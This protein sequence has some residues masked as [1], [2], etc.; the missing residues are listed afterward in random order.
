[1]SPKYNSMAMCRE[2]SCRA[3][4]HT[5]ESK[6]VKSSNEHTHEPISKIFHC[7]EVKAGIKRRA[8]ES[9]KPTHSIVASK[10]SKLE[11]ES[12]VS[13]PRLD[14]L[15][16]TICRARKKAENIHSEPTSLDTLQIPEVYTRTSKGEPF[17]LYDSGSDAE[18]TRIIIFGTQSNLA[19]LNTS[20][21]WLAD[22]TFKV[23]PKLFLQL[24]VIHG[25]K[26]GQILSK[27]NIFSKLIC[28]IA[29]K[30]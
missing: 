9:Q 25:L 21:I 20:S 29:I 19:T 17:L 2:K 24:Y 27:M 16:R 28:I 6:V 18:N 4:I 8:A 7:N 5:N 1:M 15:K 10:I 30:I 26:G 22:G 3:R 23:A 14:S 11:E 12:A 13:L